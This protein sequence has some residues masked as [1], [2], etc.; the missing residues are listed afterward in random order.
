MLFPPGSIAAAP[1]LETKKALL[2][3]DLQNDFVQPNGQLPVQNVRHFVPD[4]PV[5]ASAFRHKGDV[6]WIRTEYSRPRSVL[7]PVTGGLS[8]VLKEFV[9]LARQEDGESQDDWNSATPP[10]ETAK[11]AEA[12]ASLPDPDA[13][14][15]PEA[16]LT[17]S[18]VP[19]HKQCCLPNTP[20]SQFPDVLDNSINREKDSV[21]LKSQ[22]SAFMETTLLQTLRS[23]CITQ[24]Y[25]CG[26]LSNVSVYATVLDAVTHGMKV[27]LVED[28]LGYRDETCHREAMRQMADN[29]DVDGI[30]QQE[31]MDDLAGLLGD[32]IKEEDYPTQY[33]VSMAVP[34]PGRTDRETRK[35]SVHDWVASLEN[36]PSNMH[37]FQEPMESV[38]HV[39]RVSDASSHESLHKVGPSPQPCIR[40]TTPEMS[41]PRKRSMSDLEPELEAP[42]SKTTN[43]P[44]NRRASS[45]I[46]PGVAAK[47]KPP[48]VRNRGSKH[49]SSRDSPSPSARPMSPM[50]Q[51]KST[52][53]IPV[54]K[55]KI[56]FDC[57]TPA[58]TPPTPSQN[59]DSQS[60]NKSPNQ[61]IT[62]TPTVAPNKPNPVVLT[63]DSRIVHDF[64]PTSLSETIFDNLRGEIEWAK[65][66]H[67]TGEVPRLVAVQGASHPSSKTS[68]P[69]Y[70]HPADRS[71]PLLPFTPTVQLIRQYCEEAAG[72]PF[73]HVLIQL[74]RSGEDNISE[75]SDKT[76]D[77]VRNSNIVNYSC[78]AQRTMTLR[79]KKSA[80]STSPDPEVH[81][82]V[83]DRDGDASMTPNIRPSISIPLPHNSLFI[84]TSQT[85]TNYLHSIRRDRRPSLQKTESELAYN[86]ER[87]SLTFR[88]IG[89]FIDDARPGKTISEKTTTSSTHEGALGAHDQGGGQTNE[90]DGRVIWG[91]GA[92]GKTRATARPIPD[93]ASEQAKTEGEAMIRAMGA[94][95]H[96]SSLPCPESAVDPGRT[97]WKKG[98][99]W[100]WEKWYGGGFDV[101]DFEGAT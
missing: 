11:P 86:S 98:D 16:F 75:H 22:Y 71:P 36:P 17:V 35:Q 80:L 78:G 4:L 63:H 54:T 31:L 93:P 87:I 49:P 20:G 41:P 50:L 1:Q 2:L 61:T 56:V 33:K 52:G 29:M 45:E 18:K 7:S 68:I 73:N 10:S 25:M 69:I 14:Q 82:K 39:D 100:D 60:S 65:M 9:E 64:L 55:S 47:Y 19:G 5:L 26:S 59:A 6:I 38:E 79:L 24:L 21:V 96:L 40:Q 3:I 12:A 46:P 58:S 34:P 66:Y 30:D 94:E 8:I 90:E 48:R 67:R 99:V 77:V 81:L 15:D 51:S 72:H 95:N 53:D 89:T 101:V 85:N 76:L 23:K 88:H 97:A 28:C 91:Q 27:V 62:T 74:Y 43:K 37:S 44:S 42:L 57:E 70:R 32:V 92:T 84:L 83:Y 13:T